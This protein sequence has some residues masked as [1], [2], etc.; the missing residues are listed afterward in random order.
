MVWIWLGI[1]GD[2]SD[3]VEKMRGNEEDE[4]R[5]VQIKLRFGMVFI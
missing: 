5:K 1:Q 3:G 4:G 2:G